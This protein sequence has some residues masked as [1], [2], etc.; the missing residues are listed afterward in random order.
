MIDRKI[1][2]YIDIN[3]NYVP[4]YKSIKKLKEDNKLDEFLSGLDS[5]EIYLEENISFTNIL[6]IEK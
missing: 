2:K 3:Y 4:V 5:E 6:W 1:Y